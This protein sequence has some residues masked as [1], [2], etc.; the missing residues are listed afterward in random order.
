MSPNLNK[1]PWV[2]IR[3]GNRF[4]SLHQTEQIWQF[5]L[6]HADRVR[7]WNHAFFDV[8]KNFLVDE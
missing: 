6:V 8:L 4:A 2:S 3:D 1:L 7:K 5:L